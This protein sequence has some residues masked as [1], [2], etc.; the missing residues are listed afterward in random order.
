[1]PN[2][3]VIEQ[4]Y[5]EL[6]HLPGNDDHPSHDI[7]EGQKFVKEVYEALRS[8][9]QWDEI[10]FVIVYDE[11]GGFYD[12]VPTPLEGVPNPDG[13]VGPAPYNFNFHRLGVRVPAILVSPWIEPGTGLYINFI[14]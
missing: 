2:Y 3:T 13:I 9:P 1:M 5:F 4:R 12:H 8:S 14:C 11:H 7:A 6:S 10:L